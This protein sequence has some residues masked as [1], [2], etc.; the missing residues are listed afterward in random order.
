MA[1]QHDNHKDESRAIDHDGTVL[2]I[3]SDEVREIGRKIAMEGR[4]LLCISEVEDALAV[5][6][7]EKPSE[8]LI[9][10]LENALRECRRVM[11]RKL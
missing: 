5:N 4:I 10:A 1:N 7:L 8:K 11:R 9:H 2:P 6:I 3:S